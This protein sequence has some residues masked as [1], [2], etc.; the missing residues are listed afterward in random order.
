MS[1]KLNDIMESIFESSGL[2]TYLSSI[3]IEP[4]STSREKKIGHSRSEKFKKW[5]SDRTVEDVAHTKSPTKM[6]ARQLKIQKNKHAVVG[7]MLNGEAVCEDKFQ[8]PQAATQTVGMEIESSRKKELSKSARMIKALYKH[9]RSVKEETYAHDAEREYIPSKKGEPKQPPEDK[10]MYG[11]KPKARAVM[12]GGKTIT[13][14]K[15]DDVEIDPPMVMP[16]LGK[17]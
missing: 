1:K 6:R 12:S 2:N 9:H 10:N 4:T 7:T 8:D 5:K 15:R 11:D 3:G 13:D 17:K 16:D 14:Q